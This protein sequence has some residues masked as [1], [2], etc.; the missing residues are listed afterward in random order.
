MANSKYILEIYLPGSVGDVMFTVESESPFMT[1]TAG[2][3]LNPSVWET[4]YEDQG[5][6]LLR[7]VRLEHII[8]DIRGPNHKICVFTEA[9]DNTKEARLYQ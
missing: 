7:I 9:V 2:D 8:W 1:I 3:L 6:K 5:T 4:A